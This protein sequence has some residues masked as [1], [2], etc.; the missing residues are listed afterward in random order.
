MVAHTVEIAGRRLVILEEAD[1]LRLVA[2][3]RTRAASA[4]LPPLPARNQAGR[5]P[6]AQYIV[7][8]IARDIIRERKAA[9]LT[10]AQ[11]A[12]RAR[13]PSEMLARIEAA[14]EA[15][16]PRM[17]EKIDRALKSALVEVS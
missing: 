16:T 6:A 8:S 4:E 10:Q 12:K 7:T 1:Y 17:L 15:P 11:L 14:R 5:R 3:R 13:I 2:R 9:G